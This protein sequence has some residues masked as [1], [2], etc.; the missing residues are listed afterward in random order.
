M[1]LRGQT[2]KSGLRGSLPTLICLCRRLSSGQL[3]DYCVAMD[4][5]Q[6]IHSSLRESPAT[7]MALNSN[8]PHCATSIRPEN[9]EWGGRGGLSAKQW[10]PPSEPW[11]HTWMPDGKANYVFFLVGAPSLREHFITSGNHET[12]RSVPVLG[13]GMKACWGDAV[14][15]GAEAPNVSVLSSESRWNK[16]GLFWRGHVVHHNY[17]LPLA[18]AEFPARHRSMIITRS[19]AGS[20]WLV[21]TQTVQGA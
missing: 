12:A 13:F 7:D 16:T 20:S 6:W 5:E 11:R 4:C 8:Q 18:M 21:D 19:L 1:Q 2:N 10:P 15:S 14:F 17:R 3:S 9:R